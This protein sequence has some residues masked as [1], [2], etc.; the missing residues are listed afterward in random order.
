MT[1]V[2]SIEELPADILGPRKKGHPSDPE[3]RAYLA[4][5]RRKVIQ[6]LAN[7]ETEKSQQRKLQ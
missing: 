7:K 4:E 6:L 3:F 2:P 5:R 1:R